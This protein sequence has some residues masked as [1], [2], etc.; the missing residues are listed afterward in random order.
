MQSSY[1]GRNTPDARS[2]SLT[3]SVSSAVVTPISGMRKLSLAEDARSTP[4][5]KPQTHHGH[6]G[7]VPS[8]GDTA[9]VTARIP[10]L[11]SSDDSTVAPRDTPPLPALFSSDDS[12]VAP[13]DTPP[14]T[15]YRPLDLGPAP[16]GPSKCGWP[17]LYFCDMAAGFEAWERFRKDGMTVGTAFEVAF[18][19]HSR[20]KQTF[21]DNYRAFKNARESPG[22]VQRWKAYGRTSKGEWASFRAA[23]G[24]KRALIP[25]Q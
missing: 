21:S 18:P 4:L 14:L 25:L 9:V 11:F 12:T 1:H 15:F 3:P 8:L 17:W 2:R 23:W 19:G 16:R 22:M 13:R 10:A 7:V 24:K 5:A 20:K 6:S